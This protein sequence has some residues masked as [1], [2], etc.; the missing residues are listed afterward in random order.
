[1]A[2]HQQHTDAQQRF[3]TVLVARE[4]TDP[5]SDLENDLRPLCQRLRIVKSLTGGAHLL[6]PGSDGITVAVRAYMPRDI[7]ATEKERNERGRGG[8][9]AENGDGSLT[10][11]SRRMK[12]FLVRLGGL[13]AD[14]PAED[15]SEVEGGGDLTRETK[16]DRNDDD[17]GDGMDVDGLRAFRDSFKHSVVIFVLPP[18]EMQRDQL[19]RMDSFVAEAQRALSMPSRSSSAARAAAAVEG[20]APL[21]PQDSRRRP[22]RP[23]R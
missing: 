13:A 19:G 20:G 12:A 8:D 6:L 9:D 3:G 10:A 4:N 22:T 1:M 18:G 14:V 2:Y 23:V 15:S 16:V 5:P 7:I 11:A 21:T 17:D